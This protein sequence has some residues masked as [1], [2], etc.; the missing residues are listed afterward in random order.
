MRPPGEPTMPIQPLHTI[1]RRVRRVLLPARTGG[2]NDA[3]LL[4]RFL[5]ERDE[6]AFE[7]LVWR[8]GPMVRSVCRRVLHDEHAADDAFQATFFTLARKGAS[9]GRRESVGG[10][11]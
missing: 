2:V 9:V 3:E 7:L 4:S 6:A 1:L 5:A 10:W 8:H 11:L